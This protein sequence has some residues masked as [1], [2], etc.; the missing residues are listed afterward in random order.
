MAIHGCKHYTKIR[1]KL[2]TA[3]H[4]RLGPQDDDVD[5]S[6]RREDLSWRSEE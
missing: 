2:G 5:L 6:R 1:T 4:L 3:E